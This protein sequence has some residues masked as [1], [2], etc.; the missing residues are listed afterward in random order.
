MSNPSIT[1]TYN[2][3][4]I[5]YDESRNLWLFVLR[6]RERSASSLALAKEAIDKPAPKEAKPFTKIDAWFIGYGESGERVE[7]TAIAEPDRGGKLAVWIKRPD[8]KRS[9]ESAAYR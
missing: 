4:V 7:I 5:A 6:G 9:K 8:G 1:C 3:T 2:E